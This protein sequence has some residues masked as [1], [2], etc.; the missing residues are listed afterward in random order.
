MRTPGGCAANCALGGTSG[1]FTQLRSD[2][3]TESLSDRFV[4]E[5]LHWGFALWRRLCR[6]LRARGQHGRAWC[7]GGALDL[8]AQ[9]RSQIKAQA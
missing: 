9:A 3:I 2:L 1:H 8:D 7:G 5:H 6:S 4:S